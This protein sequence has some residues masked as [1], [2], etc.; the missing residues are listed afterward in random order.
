MAGLYRW[1]PG[2]SPQHAC[3]LP[4]RQKVRPTWAQFVQ[5]QWSDPLTPKKTN[6]C[7]KARV[8]D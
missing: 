8:N 4:E 2:K 5:Q 1:S 6:V 7:M 3:W